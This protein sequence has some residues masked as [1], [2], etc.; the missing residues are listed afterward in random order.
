MSAIAVSGLSKTYGHTQAL[1]AVS[2]E[3]E[4]G[5]MVALIGASAPAR[6]R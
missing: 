3:L 4:R 1:K 5:E 2:L 6:A